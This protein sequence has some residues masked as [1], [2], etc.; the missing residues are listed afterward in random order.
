MGFK[1]LLYNFHRF[2]QSGFYLDFIVKK[3]SEVFIRNVLIYASIFFGEKFIIEYITKK[4]IDS[5]VFNYNKNF[6]VSNLSYL[7]YFSQIVSFIFYI[8]FFI[9]IFTFLFI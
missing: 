5:Y 3:L 4:I 8:F 1:V 6:Y 7:F 9:N 2:I